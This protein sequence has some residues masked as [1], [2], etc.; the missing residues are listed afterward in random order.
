MLR[1]L[2]DGNP[3]IYRFSKGETV[4]G[5][6][7]RPEGSTGGQSRDEL[8][9]QSDRPPKRESEET[10]ER[11]ESRDRA[12]KAGPVME[13]NVPLPHVPLP[14]KEE[15][16]KAKGKKIEEKK[17]KET[18]SKSKPEMSQSKAASSAALPK[19]EAASS[20]VTEFQQT[21]GSS[22]S[23]A[24]PPTDLYFTLVLERSIIS[25]KIAMA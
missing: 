3:A 5:L 21:A 9:G 8:R 10:S 6:G 23:V 2:V 22:S 19:S 24:P 11:D 16:S 13:E 4:L 7:T 14:K 17:T 12:F 18:D 20:S 15:G 1:H 25:E